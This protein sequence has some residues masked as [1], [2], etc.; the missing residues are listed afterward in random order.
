MALVKC[1]PTRSI[2]RPF[3]NFATGPLLAQ[4][5]QEDRRAFVTAALAKVKP[6]S[7]RPPRTERELAELEVQVEMQQ[8]V[9]AVLQKAVAN[10]MAAGA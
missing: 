8:A 6:E 10:V 2:P 9:T 4:L 5:D 7:V 3:P 1:G